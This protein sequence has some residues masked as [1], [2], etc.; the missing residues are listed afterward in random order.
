[1]DRGW[2]F[3][4]KEYTE[5]VIHLHQEN[6]GIGNLEIKLLVGRLFVLMMMGQLWG[7]L[8]LI[9]GRTYLGLLMFS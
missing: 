4:L 7:M 8:E 3:S 9:L 2:K 1:L 6:F 5:Q